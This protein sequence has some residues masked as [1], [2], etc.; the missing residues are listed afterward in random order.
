MIH[1]FE[2]RGS[3][4][5]SFPM[6]HFFV[7]RENRKIH[8]IRKSTSVI[9]A[10]FRLRELRCFEKEEREREK[11]M[12]QVSTCTTFFFRLFTKSS[13]NNDD[14]VFLAFSHTKYKFRTTCAPHFVEKKEKIFAYF[15]LSLARSLSL[16]IILIMGDILYFCPS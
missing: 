4:V 14:D 13:N 16:I 1:I 6:N 5:Q 12:Q 2:K 10:F 3:A 9:Q 15:F 11:K 8:M 7:T